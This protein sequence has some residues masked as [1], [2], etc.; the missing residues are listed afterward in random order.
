[1]GLVEVV[2]VEDEVALRRGVEAEVAQVRVPQITG[3]MPVAGSPEKSSAMT[4]AAPRRKAKGLATIRPIRTGTRR[5]TRPSLAAITCSTGSARRSFPSQSA[6]V[7]R[8][9]CCRSPRPIA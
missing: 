5:P 8:G 9:T 2:E 7:E 3:V 1:M 6:S 4:A